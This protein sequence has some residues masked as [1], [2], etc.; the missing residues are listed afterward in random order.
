MAAYEALST[1][2][3]PA[4]RNP[5]RPAA[6]PSQD[7]RPLLDAAELIRHAKRSKAELQRASVV[8]V[9]ESDVD[10]NSVCGDIVEDGFAGLEDEAALAATTHSETED[11]VEL[12][13]GDSTGQSIDEV[14][15]GDWI[16]D[17]GKCHIFEDRLTSRLSYEERFDDGGRLH[18]WLVR[19]PEEEFEAAA[20]REDVASW[21]AKLWLLHECQDNW[22]GP[23]CGEEPESVGDIKVRIRRSAGLVL[24][25]QI[26]VKDE[27]GEYDDWQPSVTWRK[28]KRT[29]LVD[30]DN[31]GLFV[32]GGGS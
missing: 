28:K 2:V 17:S 25:S 9:P 5:S 30:A 26:R 12:D 29:V 32:F 21:Q 23:S 18:G 31:N 27:C 1:H 6:S 3:S 20:V 15:R 22:Y 8:P 13:D 16:S 7:R 14:L 19:I 11:A 10:Q 4:G 24:E